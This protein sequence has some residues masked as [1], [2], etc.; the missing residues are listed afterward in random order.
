MGTPYSKGNE[1]QSQA[2]HAL[3]VEEIYPVFFE[4]KKLEIRNFAIEKSEEGKRMDGEYGVDT[5][6]KVYDEGHEWPLRF[7]FQERFRTF[8][9]Y[10]FRE[11]TITCWNPVTYLP[12]ELYKMMAGYMLYAYYDITENEFLEAIIICVPRVIR[13]YLLGK[14]KAET[15]INPRTRQ[16]FIGFKI[17]ELIEKGF[18]EYHYDCADVWG[19]NLNA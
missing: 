7:W 13:A 5:E 18:S 1:K 11:L 12:S 2:G 6:I 9:D 16:P 8:D 19:E 4:H 3:A 10:R 14:L 17:D 15:N